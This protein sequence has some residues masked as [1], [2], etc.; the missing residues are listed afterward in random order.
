MS[1]RRPILLCAGLLTVAGTA[2]AQVTSLISLTNFQQAVDLSYRGDASQ[3]SV[4]STT[5]H[6]LQEDYRLTFDYAVYRARLLHGQITLDLQGDQ[7]LFSGSGNS[8]GI[9]SG[10]SFL[11]D[12]SGVF[13]DRFPTPVT[14][15][16]S[17]SISE[18][19]RDFASSYEQK[20]D[21]Y[22]VAASINNDYIPVAMSF[23]RTTTETSGLETDRGQTSDTVSLGASHTYKQ[24]SQTQFT[25]INTTQHLDGTDA[26]SSEDT[27]D[28]ELTLNNTL[29]FGKK[30][31]NRALYTRLRIT[32]QTGANQSRSTELGESLTWD[33]G[34]A[35][36]SGADYTLSDRQV[37]N[38]SQQLHR[39]RLWLQ[40]RLFR[41]VTTRLN[42]EG[43]ENF[44]GSGKE[45]NLSG[46]ITMAYFKVLPA[47]SSIQLTGHK[48]Y[49]VT[50][51]HLTDSSIVVS[52]EAH[53]VNPNEPLILS[54]MNVVPESIIVENADPIARAIPYVVN[55][56]Y[57][58]RQYGPQTE[59]YFLLPGSEIKAT[60]RLLITYSVLVNTDISYS[61][62]SQGVGSDLN[63][64]DNSYRIFASWD[65]TDQSLLSGRA[66]T[67][68]L[69]STEAYRFGVQKRL[70]RGQVTAE[71]SVTK[72]D[73]DKNQSISGSYQYSGVF[74]QGTLSFNANDRYIMTEG[75]SGTTGTTNSRSE[76]VLTAGGTYTRTLD[77]GAVLT[78]TANYLNNRGFIDS[79]NLS[80]GL[81]LRWS[82]RKL[83]MS[84]LSQANFRYTQGSMSTDQHLQ[85][86]LSRYF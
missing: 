83:T 58:V 23:T 33:L 52:K 42:L 82:L 29:T 2:Q 75:K 72:S 35:L 19:P 4:G 18:V 66:D 5:D 62:S 44:L 40:H 56:D 70:D 20:R 10:L 24:L 14:F 13:L 7:K 47:E 67:V 60:D 6:S 74:A 55:K 17:S 73:V 9:S 34:K 27:G 53:Q 65:S 64:F 22:G 3:G 8:S 31:L 54:S 26:I 86:R 46:G 84:L 39:G 48:Q 28:L 12:I 37:V 25:V 50:S 32:D 77:S 61:S 81:G 76:N 15:T 69:T 1:K 45:E 51:S 30:E 59:I 71:Y 16:V 43:S 63:L 79:D 41:S 78:A 49:G 85:L 11:Y 57:E 68:N 80:F 21:T 36:S 38:Q